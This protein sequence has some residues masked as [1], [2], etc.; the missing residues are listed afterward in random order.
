MVASPSVFI[1]DAERDAAEHY[2]K[3]NRASRS[4]AI[5]SSGGLDDN[6]A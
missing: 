5:G 3:T 1:A 2:H 6:I 4:F